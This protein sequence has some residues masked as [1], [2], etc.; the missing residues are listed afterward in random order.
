MATEE[1]FAAVLGDGGV[2]AW[3]VKDNGGDC[4][5]VQEQL[6]DVQHF[7]ATQSAFA[8]LKADGSVVTWGTR[9]NGGK[10]DHVS[11]T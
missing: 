9:S 1:A 4:S 2:V 8:A 6:K 5:A 3:G 11:K 7:A 10:S